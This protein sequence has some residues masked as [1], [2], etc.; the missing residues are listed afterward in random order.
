M[1]AIVHNVE[2]MAVP[3]KESISEFLPNINFNF[4]STAILPPKPLIQDL[5]SSPQSKNI[6]FINYFYFCCYY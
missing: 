4:E 6:K 5:S 3:L 1:M 2:E